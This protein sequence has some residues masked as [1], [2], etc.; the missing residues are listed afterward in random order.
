MGW[1]PYRKT[2]LTHHQPAHSCKGYTLL[3]PTGGDSTFLLDMDGRIVQRWRFSTIRPFYARLLENGRLLAFGTDSS[4]PPPER[5]PFDQ[6]QPEW[7]ARARLLGGGGTHLLELDWDGAVVWQYEN[8]ALHHDFVRLPNGNTLLPVWV[9]LPP[10]IARQVRG[11]PPLRPREKRP[12]LLGDDVIE[13]D[14]H[15]N[16]VARVAISTALDPRRD[17][18]CSLETGWEWTH[19]NS[20]A[21][22]AEGNL[23][24]SCRTNSRVSIV[25][26]PSGTLLWKYGFPEVSHQHHAT[27]LPNG[28]VQIFDNGMHRIGL[29]RSRVVE[30]NPKDNSI[31]WE[32]S[33]EPFEQFFSAHVSGAERLPGG[34]VL[35]CEGAP[36]RIFEVT[37]RGET[38]WEWV[39]PFVNR[40]QGRLV[41]LIYR[42]HRYLPD[43]P[44]LAGRRLDPADHAELN[45]LHGLGERARK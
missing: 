20:I 27:P 38:V 32:Y 33:G 25:E 39:N 40:Q 10:E 37:P 43:F 34:N 29:P 4:L 22:T 8:P 15:G 35:I 12:P 26:R 21:L 7:P 30:V 3:T 24:F 18:L 5:P 28:N 14:P 19:L 42:T 31:A 45:R 44:G 9:E 2:G 17:P 41:T 11:L 6:P 1:S 13:I 36:G 23:L 16:E